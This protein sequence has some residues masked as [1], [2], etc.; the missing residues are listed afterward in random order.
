MTVDPY[1]TIIVPTFNEAPN[2]EPLV[3]RI[4][5]ALRGTAVEVLFVD[6]SSD[7]TPDEVRRVSAIAPIPVRLLHREEAVGGLS[8]AV[9]EGIRAARSDVCVVMDG[10]LQHPP[11]VIP[12]LIARFG[13][14]DAD[15]V[16]ASRY[17]AEGSSK[18]LAGFH[19][20]LVSRTTTLLT[21]A[22][23]PLRLR[24]CSDPMTGFFLVDRSRIEMSSLRPRGFKI[25]LEIL[26][27]REF[28]VAEVPFDFAERNAGDSKASF[29]QG[30]HFLT[31]LA[32]LRFGKMSGF[33]LIGGAGALLNLL[34]MFLLTNAGMNYVIAAIIAA[35]IT[36]VLNFLLQDRLVFHDMTDQASPRLARFAKSFAFNNAE[37]VIR[38]PMMSLLVE[39]WHISSLVATAITLVIAFIA[40]YAFHA[41]VVYA[42]RRAERT[43]TSTVV[44]GA[45]TQSEAA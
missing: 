38:I 40:R 13:Q 22:M 33:A 15:V 36:I 1:V 17:V 11:E 37:A 14:G 26:A 8:G 29:A 10:D 6:D 45:G 23:F 19:R 3:E 42:P 34:I 30:L 2:V 4:A 31:Q 16:V 44:S 21:K 7:R 27:R 43:D 39:T 41:L 28:R 20:N 18:G 9:V 25:L 24:N 32:V 35:E 5:A 12:D